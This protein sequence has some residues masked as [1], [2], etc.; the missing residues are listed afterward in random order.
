[1]I[2]STCVEGPH[3]PQL[4]Y[5]CIGD[6]IHHLSLGHI[7]LRTYIFVY[8]SFLAFR[9]LFYFFSLFL[10]LDFHLYQS[11]FSEMVIQSESIYVY[12]ARSLVYVYVTE[13]FCDWL[14]YRELAG[15]LEASFDQLFHPTN[16]YESND[17]L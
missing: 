6:F 9:Y 12:S 13:Y 16:C 11:I 1:M 7:H 14:K 8:Q 17:R 2:S 15:S 5:M 3:S 4:I 10:T